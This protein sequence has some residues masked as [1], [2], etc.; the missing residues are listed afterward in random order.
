[1]S[2][3]LVRVV[4]LQKSKL[5]ERVKILLLTDYEEHMLANFP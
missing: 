3:N 1:M 4:D 5:L 2:C